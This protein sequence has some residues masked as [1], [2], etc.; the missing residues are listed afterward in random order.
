VRRPLI[1]LA[2]IVLFA[3]AGFGVWWK[4]FRTSP[5]EE[6]PLKLTATGFEDVPGWQGA[7]LSAALSAFRRSCV[8]I[9]DL[10]PSAPM[11]YAGTAGDWRETCGNAF[12]THDA[13]H[14]FE[15]SFT[16]HTVGSG[17]GLVTGYY[18]PLLSG[19]RTRHAQYQTP[20]YG[21]PQDLISI[22]LG[23]FR[24][25]WKGE[26]LYGHLDGHKFLPFPT[27]AQIDEKPP[28]KTRILFYG[29]D[30]VSVFFLHIQGSGR[31]WLDDGSIVRVTYAGQNGH[32]Y[33]PVGRVLIR[34]FGVPREG[35]SMQVIRAWLK[36]HPDDERKVM[37]TDAS[38]V[39]FDEK[40]V[41]DPALGPEGSGGVALT[42]RASIAIDHRIH[43][44][45][46]PVFI[47]GDSLA[48]LF[49]AQDTGGAIR[50]AARADIF[51]GFGASAEQTAGG[52]KADA[53]F[54][55]LLPRGLKP[56]LPT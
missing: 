16:P 6:A 15:T 51:F 19:S 8:R 45:G 23:D 38:F 43:P 24:P 9:L 21:M 28:E 48:N 40:P 46:M 31:V 26:T 50:G 4:L 11:A 17:D 25:E 42:P 10:P 52:M 47:T 49:I 5:S 36:D 44:F 20:V 14:F 32:P 3:A 22:D 37:E 53:R 27:R 54:Y 30:P 56:K 33:T 41:G 1:I 12:A 34:K 55:V 18:E 29:D 35:M 13:R 2:I 7:D 39:F